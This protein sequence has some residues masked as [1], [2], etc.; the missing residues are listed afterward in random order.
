MLNLYFA[1]H[2]LAQVGE[3]GVVQRGIVGQAG[4]DGVFAAEGAHGFAGVEHIEQHQI[5]GN[6]AVDNGFFGLGAGYLGHLPQVF[7]PEAVFDYGEYLLGTGRRPLGHHLP[8]HGG[9]GGEEGV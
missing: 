1:L 6:R 3:G 8:H 2:I 9:V 5:A 4:G 7:E